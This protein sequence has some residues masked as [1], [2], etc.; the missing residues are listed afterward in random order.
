MLC[1]SCGNDSR[2]VDSRPNTDDS[3]VMR[4]RICVTCK[5]RWTTHEHGADYPSAV[6]LQQAANA[7]RRA[8]LIIDDALSKI[9]EAIKGSADS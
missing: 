7:L 6:K 9:D 3:A 5:L 8:R 4:R 1:P 2:V